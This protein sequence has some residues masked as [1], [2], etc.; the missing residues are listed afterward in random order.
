[1]E[2]MTVFAQL[3]GGPIKTLGALALSHDHG[4]ILDRFHGAQSKRI[5]LIAFIA[6]YTKN[7]G[8]VN[9]NA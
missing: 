4:L 5:N 1:M 8:A 2:L 9:R 3:M 6:S 7:H